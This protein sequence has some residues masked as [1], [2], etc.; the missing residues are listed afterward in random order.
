MPTAKQTHRATF[1]RGAAGTPAALQ[2]TAQINR[3]ADAAEIAKY[4]GGRIVHLNTDG[5]WALGV[6]FDGSTTAPTPYIL[7]ESYTG[8]DRAASESPQTTGEMHVIG[9]NSDYTVAPRANLTATQ[10]QA[11]EIETTEFA[12]VSFDIG[13]LVKADGDGIIVK[14]TGTGNEVVLGSVT[15]PRANNSYGVEV[16]RIA[17][18]AQNVAN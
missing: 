7:E 6:A 18:N 1:I 8:F 12:A 14:A 4:L 13:D 3:D 5:E 16:L 15:K 2:H 10:C 17:F 11:V 9:V